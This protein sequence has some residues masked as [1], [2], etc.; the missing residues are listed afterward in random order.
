MRS[1][2]KQKQ[3]DSIPE[4]KLLDLKMTKGT[5]R[6]NMIRNGRIWREHRVKNGVD[7]YKIYDPTNDKLKVLKRGVAK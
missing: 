2:E 7:H 3:I 4:L 6:V 1:S 5:G